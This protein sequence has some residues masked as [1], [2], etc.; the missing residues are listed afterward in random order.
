MLRLQALIRQKADSGPVGDRSPAGAEIDDIVG[1]SGRAIRPV[2]T[3]QVAVGIDPQTG[4]VIV[5]ERATTD[6][7]MVTGRV[8]FDTGVVQLV[9]D[10]A[11]CFDPGDEAYLC[12]AR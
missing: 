11:S 8:Q 2:A 5:V 6:E 10:G 4:R 12:H 9:E 7:C 3:P 1:A